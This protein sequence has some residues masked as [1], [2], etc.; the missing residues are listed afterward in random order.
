MAITVCL[1]YDDVENAIDW[2]HQALGAIPVSRHDTDGQ[3]V[4]AE[5]DLDGTPLLLRRSTTGDGVPAPER[6]PLL[7][8]VEALDTAYQR[9]LTVG[10][11]ATSAPAPDRDGRRAFTTTDPQGYRWT[12]TEAA[13]T[14]HDADRRLGTLADLCTPYA[15]RVLATL[16]VPDRID[17]GVTALAPLASACGADADALGRLLR[18]LAHRGVV[19]EPEP[20]VFT[21]TALGRLLCERGPA[22]QRDWL[23]LDGLGARMDLAYRGLLHAVRTGTAGYE[24]VHGR[25][26]WADL[27]AEPALRSYFDALMMSQQHVTAPQ[28]AEIYDWSGAE[29]VFD[30]GGGSGAL[31][32]ELLRRHPH[33]R[34]TFVDRPIA[35]EAA[36]RRYAAEGLAERVATVAGDF[37]SPLPGGGD[38]YVVSRALTDWNDR[39]AVAIL[40]RCA[41]AAGADGRVLVVEVLPTEPYV[42]HRSPFDLQMLAVVG[43]RERG[44]V[45]FRAIGAA[46]GLDLTTVLHGRAGLTVMEYAATARS[47]E[48]AAV[49]DGE[50]GS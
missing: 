43:G 27:D 13:V 23:D 19:S 32:A 38:V 46:A 4:E 48:P 36:A 26:F 31:L 42:P 41:D 37:F 28:V 5:L 35:A 44:L 47:T 33:L 25:T 2:L 11:A 39:D 34:G 3:V 1:Q 15:V 18:Y 30:V 12:V 6:V 20:D 10:G 45:D 40:R 50:R 24:Q 16:R 22:G 21:L 8:T 14:D 49:G 9:M 17:S 7:V 29:H